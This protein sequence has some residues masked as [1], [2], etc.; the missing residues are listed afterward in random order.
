MMREAS[1]S[2]DL[3]FLNGNLVAEN[4]SDLWCKIVFLRGF[5]RFRTSVQL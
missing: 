5:E 2:C 4:R 3:Q 1:Y